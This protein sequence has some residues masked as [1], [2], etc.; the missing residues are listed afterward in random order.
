MEIR[1][2][3]SAS[4]TYFISLMTVIAFLGPV[5]IMMLNSLKSK[6]EISVNPLGFPEIMRWDN[7][8]IAWQRAG[9]LNNLFNS[10]TVTAGTVLLIILTGALASYALARLKIGR[11][12]GA[13]FALFILGIILPTFSGLIPL[14]KLMQLFGLYDTLLGLMLIYAAAGLPITILIITKFFQS[15]PYE[16]EEAAKIDGLG[17]LRTFWSIMLPL[18][19]PAI[20]TTIIINSLS[21]WNDFF[22]VLVFT[23]DPSNYTLTRGLVAFKSEFTVDWSLLFAAST[24]IALPVFLL[25]LF[26]QRFLIDGLTS[27]AIKG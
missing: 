10:V 1:K 24:M 11:I 7:Y 3:I 14:F 16:L 17:Y 19:L 2:R 21:V 20:V 27:G 22:T 12:S 6:E 9:L 18:A 25:F 26:L 13:I 5:S 15:V 4:M 8:E 23:S